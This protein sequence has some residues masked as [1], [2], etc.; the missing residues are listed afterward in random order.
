MEGLVQV[1]V[2]ASRAAAHGN[3]AA[4]DMER[5]TGGDANQYPGT[6]RGGSLAKQ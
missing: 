3:M 5:L 2:T 6:G 1:A 4:R